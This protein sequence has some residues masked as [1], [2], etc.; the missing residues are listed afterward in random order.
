MMR[1]PPRGLLLCALLCACVS[2]RTRQPH[3]A[4][5]S[6]RPAVVRVVLPANGGTQLCSGLVFVGPTQVQVA[7]LQGEPPERTQ[8]LDADAATGTQRP[9]AVLPW[10]SS[11]DDAVA[12]EDGLLVG[13]QVQPHQMVSEVAELSLRPTATAHTVGGVEAMGWVRLRL[14]HGAAG[15]V[16]TGVEADPRAPRR[17]GVW[18]SGQVPGF[19]P[20]AGAVDCQGVAWWPQRNAAL[21]GCTSPSG[22]PLAAWVHAEGVE[23]EAL[24]AAAALGGW[25]MVDV[26]VD[27]RGGGAALLGCTPASCAL[28]RSTSLGAWVAAPVAAA[29]DAARVCARGPVTLVATRSGGVYRYAHGAG[30]ALRRGRPVSEIAP[31]RPAFAPDCTAVAWAEHGLEGAAPAVEVLSLSHAL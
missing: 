20:V 6:A 3:G 17:V 14:A 31:P 27:A 10:V 19:V 26:A 13:A 2:C 5:P 1:T 7:L 15:T 30:T 9:V 12:T 29:V 28:W 21:V 25:H 23:V 22:M 8:W 16:V 4:P 11:V 18:G 24:D